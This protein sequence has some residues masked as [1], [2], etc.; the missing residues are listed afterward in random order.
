LIN[1]YRGKEKNMTLLESFG[2]QKHWIYETIIS[3]TGPDGRTPHCAPM[4][5]RSRDLKHLQLEIFKESETLSNIIRDER[6]AVNFTHDRLLFYD[7]LFDKRNLTFDCPSKF[8]VPVLKQ[9]DASL[10]LFLASKHRQGNKFYL[11]TQIVSTVQN[12]PVT[13]VNRA[14]NLFL[15]SLVWITRFDHLPKVQVR[16]ALRE[17]MRIIRRVAPRSQYEIRLSRLLNQFSIEQRRDF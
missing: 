15:D 9:A 13:L 5:V 7:V 10:E 4:G 14:E 16:A 17:N 1:D 2:M 12:E 6:F 11:E 3:T 8:S